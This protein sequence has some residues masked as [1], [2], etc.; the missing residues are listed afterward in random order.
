MGHLSNQGQ[1]GLLGITCALA[2]CCLGI[3]YLL[4]AGAPASYSVVNAMA[5]L[6]GVVAL[7]GVRGAMLQA[8]RHS[9]SVLLTLSLSLLATALVGAAAEGASR[10]ILI[11]PLSVQVSLVVLPVMIVAF[12]RHPTPLGS[13]GIAVAAVALALQPDRAMAGVLAFS[14][15]VLAISRPGRLSLGA[16]TAALA[17]FLVSLARPDTLSAVPFVDQILFTAF[18]VHMLAGAAVLLGSLLLIVPAIVGWWRDAAFSHVYVVFGAVWLG[19][20]LSAALGNYPTPVV[21]Y[22]G[23]AI[24]GYLLSFSYLPPKLRSA[25]GHAPAT[26]EDDSSRL[27]G[28]P[29]SASRA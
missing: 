2:A 6:L 19:C 7:G 14:M 24:L 22:G 4:A 9:G 8:A 18:D 10:W 23:S 15:S 5:F 25:S 1:P 27:A 3:V 16:L 11:G 28:L 12:A 26:G 13:I 21:G 17:A 29:K 20:I